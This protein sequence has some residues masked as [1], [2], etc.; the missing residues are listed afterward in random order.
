MK[1]V[2]SECEEVIISVSFS[3]ENIIQINWWPLY[4]Q[5]TLSIFPGIIS[6]LIDG[7]TSEFYLSSTVPISVIATEDDYSTVINNS[8]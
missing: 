7:V 4:S 3:H 5:S 1:K 8:N 6:P 2:M